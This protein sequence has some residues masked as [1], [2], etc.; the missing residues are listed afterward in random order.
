M[1]PEDQ[2]AVLA[3]FRRSLRGE[4]HNLSDNPDLLWQQVF[5][6]LQ[7]EDDLVLAALREEADRRSGPG[8]APWIRS[9][10]P[11]AESRV[12]LRTLEGHIGEVFGCDVSADGRLV[13]SAS[14]DAT[15]RIWDVGTGAAI[16]ALTGHEGSVM[17]CAFSPDGSLVLSAGAD[18]TLRLWDVALARERAVL[19]GHTGAVMGCAFSPDGSFA[20]S[21]SGDG[22]LKIWDLASRRAPTRPSVSGTRR[23][24]PSS[25][26]FGATRPR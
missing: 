15:V 12:L 2:I 14:D 1:A 9:R 4:S 3:A 16:A 20:V 10:T 7:W 13:A 22:T 23:A 19:A 8:A 18:G 6:R 25:G 11:L 5:N 26:A 24:E 17:G 21:A